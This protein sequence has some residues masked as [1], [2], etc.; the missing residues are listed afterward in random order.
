VRA[1][2]LT[3]L[4]SI[5]ALVLSVVVCLLNVPNLYFLLVVAVVDGTTVSQNGLH[6]IFVFTAVTMFIGFAGQV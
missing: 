3:G 2:L 1:L 4:T 5:Q 6:P